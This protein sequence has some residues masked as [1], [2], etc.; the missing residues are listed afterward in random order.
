ADLDWLMDKKKV[1]SVCLGLSDAELIDNLNHEEINRLRDILFI[2]NRMIN[3]SL[4]IIPLADNQAVVYER[5]RLR[6]AAMKGGMVDYQERYKNWEKELLKFNCGLEFSIINDL[7][8][9]R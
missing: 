8:Q 2:I 6:F 3:S 4:N 1:W 5:E 7:S 9:G